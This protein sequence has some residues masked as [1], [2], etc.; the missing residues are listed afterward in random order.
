MTRLI[1][2]IAGFLALYLSAYLDLWTDLLVW[3]TDFFFHDSMVFLWS[4]VPFE[5]AEFLNSPD[6]EFVAQIV[7][8]IAWFIPF[9][10]LMIIYLEAT[11][12]ALGVLLVRYIIG[13]VPTVEG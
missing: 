12:L 1:S 11:A 10:A 3:I 9:W 2:Y 4:L 5:L 8:D 6:V 7:R 13:W